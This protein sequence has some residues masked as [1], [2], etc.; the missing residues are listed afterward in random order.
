MIVKSGSVDNLLQLIGSLLIFAAVLFV[1]W[2]VLKWM[3]NIQGK[4]M[5]NR[6][7]Q[8]LESIRVGGNKMI[9]VVRVGQVCYVVGVGRDE[10]HLIGQLDEQQA[11]V[12]Q[13]TQ[14]RNLQSF[15]SFSGVL[16]QIRG[17]AKRS[18]KDDE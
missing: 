1:V 3:G 17:K 18:E 6:N 12:F 5:K 9:T 4:Q 11:Q 8:L 16:D 7:L 14:E 2:I 15:E 13:E 10:I